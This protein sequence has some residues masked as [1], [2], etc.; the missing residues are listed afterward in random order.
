MKV[1]HNNPRT[2]RS[3]ICR[4]PNVCTVGA[5]FDSLEDAS[6]E[7]S[8]WV[9]ADVKREREEKKVALDKNP[10][11]T[12]EVLR[13]SEASKQ[14]SYGTKVRIKVGFS[15]PEYRK[16]SIVGEYEDA[17]IFAPRG[18]DRGPL[19]IGFYDE[20]DQAFV[21]G[22]SFGQRETGGKAEKFS[23]YIKVGDVVKAK[24]RA[25]TMHEI[26]IVYISEVEESSSVLFIA[27]TEY[28][29]FWATYNPTVSE[30]WDGVVAHI[31]RQL[32]RH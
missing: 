11:Y 28:D 20:D 9:E 21:A 4:Q 1:Y 25:N 2:Y 15:D 16:A 13:R 3:V 5:H 12:A 26:E 8:Q 18:K 29:Y 7:I 14:F 6:S 22:Y 24:N 32:S 19:G 17:V 31:H 10:K 30:R 27:A 23:P